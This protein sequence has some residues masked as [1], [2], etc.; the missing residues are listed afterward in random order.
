MVIYFNDKETGKQYCVYTDINGDIVVRKT[1]SIE[2][3]RGNIEYLSAADIETE[4]RE[5]FY[6]EDDEMI[7]VGFGETICSYDKKEDANDLMEDIQAYVLDGK[8]PDNRPDGSNTKKPEKI[9]H[10]YFRKDKDGAV[11]YFSTSL[12]NLEIVDGEDRFICSPE[13]M[14]IKKI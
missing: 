2:A 3:G 13:L 9:S 14:D 6:S 1:C 7:H 10:L 8:I 12:D 4:K 11:K 5:V